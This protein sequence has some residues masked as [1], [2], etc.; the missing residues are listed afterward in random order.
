[1]LAPISWLKEYVDIDISPKELEEKLF[2]AG[3]EVEEVVELGKDISGVVVGLVEEC[4][5]IPDTHIS[6]CKVNCGEK[7]TFQITYVIPEGT[8]RVHQSVMLF[9]NGSLNS[10]AF[11]STFKELHL[12][13]FIIKGKTSVSVKFYSET[14]PV[15]YTVTNEQIDFKMIDFYVPIESL[16]TYKNADGWKDFADRIF[17]I[18][19]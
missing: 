9:Y 7:G 15:I 3:F 17:P 19:E 14:P 18:A 11:P 13:S 16:D 8:E 2:S 10:V 12:V 4:S 1:M 5:R 6:V